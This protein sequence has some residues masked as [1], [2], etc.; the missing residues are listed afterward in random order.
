MY[1]HVQVIWDGRRATSRSVCCVRMAEEA[2][3][4]NFELSAF[5]LSV[6]TKLV[7]AYV[8]NMV[9]AVKLMDGGVWPEYKGPGT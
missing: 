3:V 4:I 1:L 7:D 2:T 8:T 9:A 6:G 5:V